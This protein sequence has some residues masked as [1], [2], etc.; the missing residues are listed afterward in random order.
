MKR[1]ISACIAIALCFGTISAKT[2]LV[3]S[4]LSA[5]SD[6]TLA[7]HNQDGG[8]Y[9]LYKGKY[10]RIGV[11]GFRSLNEFASNATSC[12]ATSGDTLYVAPG[13]YTEDATIKVA[14][15]TILGHNANKDWT[16][17]RNALESELQGSLSIEASNITVNGFKVTGNGRILSN[18]GTNSVPFSG[19]KVLYNYFCNSTRVRNFSY[20]LIEIGDRYA[21]ASAP[22]NT[23]Q[24]RYLNC[25]VAHNYFY[26]PE[27]TST[28]HPCGI[29]VCGAGG[30]TRVHDNYF[31][32]TGTS[33]LIENAQGNIHIDHNVF[34]V[35]SI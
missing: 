22:S 21:N 9:A 11:T 17:T 20:P 24:L 6:E 28:T 16:S 23:S 35:S 1:L 13:K 30:T 34:N 4:H 27:G 10:Y 18:A 29:A 19:I 33:V 7:T 32:E 5:V 26:L 12:G 3:D 31:H 2:F 14:G 15:L 25:E 8:T